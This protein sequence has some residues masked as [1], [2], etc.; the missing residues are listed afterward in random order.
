MSGGFG[1]RRRLRTHRPIGVLLALLILLGLSAPGAF[2]DQDAAF[3]IDDERITESSGLTADVDRELY[4]TVNDS[5][6]SGTVYALD[7]SGEVRG[8]VNFRAEVTDV[9]AVQYADNTLYV[10]DIG[11]NDGERDFVSVY[12]L[13]DLEPNDATVLYQAFDLTYPDGPQDAETLLVDADGRLLIVTKGD[14]AGIYRLPVEPSRSEV[15]TLERVA[16]AP[17]FVTDGTVLP[18][19]RIALRSYVDVKVVDPEQDYAVVAQTPL[20][21]QP[22]GESLSLDLAGENL[23][24]GSEGDGSAV[25]SVPI[26]ENVEDS[27]SAGPTPPAS[28]APSSSPTA[29]QGEA[30]GGDDGNGGVPTAGADDPGPGRTGTLVALILAGIVAVVAGG[31]VYWLRGRL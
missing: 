23:L 31:G 21:F 20:P 5:G 8:T 1:A 25:F 17:A 18:D 27:P 24:A 9:E 29:D 4:W 16:D 30:D 14:D 15:N 11:D 19:G 28:A 7:D 3:T 6:D 13:F 10:A 22:Q 12:L 26:P 2:A